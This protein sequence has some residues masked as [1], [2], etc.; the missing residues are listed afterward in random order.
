MMLEMVLGDVISLW[1]LYL[2]AKP[3]HMGIDVDG[4]ACLLHHPTICNH[5]MRGHDFPSGAISSSHATV[6]DGAFLR[7]ARPSGLDI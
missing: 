6:G 5:Q 2:V 7:D 1:R 4:L 3:S